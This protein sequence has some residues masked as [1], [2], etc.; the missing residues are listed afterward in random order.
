MPHDELALALGLDPAKVAAHRPHRI[1]LGD[2]PP[3]EHEPTTDPTGRLL[4]AGA[5]V[6]AVAEVL[7]RHEVDPAI[8]ADVAAELVGLGEGAEGVDPLAAELGLDPDR[9]ADL[10]HGRDGRRLRA[11]ADDFFERQRRRRYAA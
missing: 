10:R 1:A 3:V 5:V 8:A 2:A 7:E 4:E 11:A 9:V 6:D